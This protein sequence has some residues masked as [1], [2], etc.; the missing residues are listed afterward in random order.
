MIREAPLSSSSVGQDDLIE[1]NHS[2][3]Q[4]SPSFNDARAM[5]IAELMNDYRTLLLHIMEQTSSLPLSGAPQ[6]G[7]LVLIQSRAAALDL[8]CTRYKHSGAADKRGDEDTQTSHL[9][10]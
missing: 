6:E 7:H 4:Y 10:E 5:R 1:S 2:R 8:L 9:R 3:H